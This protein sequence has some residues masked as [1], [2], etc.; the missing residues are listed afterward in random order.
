MWP[1]ENYDIPFM[2]RNLEKWRSE[3]DGYRKKMRFW[4]S[5]VY[6]SLAVIVVLALLAFTIR[7]ATGAYWLPVIFAGCMLLSAGLMVFSILR[8]RLWENR[9]ELFSQ[10]VC[11]MEE[12]LIRACHAQNVPMKKEE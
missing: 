1:Y 5:F 4:L 9:V 10:I 2:E 6:L 12:E 3:M 8:W 7:L 11:P